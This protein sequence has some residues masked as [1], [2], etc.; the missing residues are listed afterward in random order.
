MKKKYIEPQWEVFG[1][2]IEAH[3]FSGTVE[4]NSLISPTGVTNQR[5]RSTHRG[6]SMWS[7]MEESSSFGKPNVDF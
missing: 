1:F 5:S 2:E 6:H 7:S 4:S 3:I